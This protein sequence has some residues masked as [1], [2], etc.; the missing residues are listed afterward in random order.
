[1][2]SASAP[3][4]SNALRLPVLGGA[5]TPWPCGVEVAEKE[6]EEAEAGERDDAGLGRRCKGALTKRGSW[7]T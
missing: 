7:T 6:K 3:S 4:S 2:F 1:M 5:C